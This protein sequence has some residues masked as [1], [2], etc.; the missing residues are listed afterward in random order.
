MKLIDVFNG[1]ADGICALLQWRLVH[2]GEAVRVTGVKRDNALLRR[3]AS[4]VGVELLVLDINFDNNR[5]DVVRLLDDGASIRYFDHHYPGAEVAALARHPR[6][7]L[8]VDESPDVCT[9]LLVHRALNGKQAAWA[10][11]GAF[12]DNL[13][14][15]ATAL[16]SG[17][18]F[19]AAQTQSL[20][21][22]GEL[23][24]YN[25][26]GST[27]ADLH[28]DPAALY[29]VLYEYRDPFAFIAE[30]DAYARLLAGHA[31]DMAAASGMRPHE[32]N[33]LGRVYVLPDRPWARRVIGVW[34][35]MLSQAD[36]T[37]AHLIFCPDGSG[38]Y[39]ASV[40]AAQA[41]PHGAAEFCRQFPGGG[42]R[43]AAGGITALSEATLA[44][45]SARFL[46]AFTPN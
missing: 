32:E 37:R 27:L 34:A 18:G 33:S 12:G 24:N 13:P 25:G 5:R 19:D 38:T 2:P 44:D 21:T 42:G 28:F 7:A 39:T 15:V 1:D 4:G 29:A 36:K 16:A 31:E 14:A 46:S 35:N 8:T 40:R 3:V 23:L 30:A 9:S 11:A 45:V 20:R 6:L 26:Y 10:V 41:R 43:A 22:L 17:S